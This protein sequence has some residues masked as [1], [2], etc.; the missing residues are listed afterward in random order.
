[1]RAAYL[2]L[3]LRLRVPHCADT[4][5]HAGG[6]GGRR[7]RLRMARGGACTAVVS[8]ALAVY[9]MWTGLK[10]S[11]TLSTRA[12]IA[13]VRRR[14]SRAD[15]TDVASLR[16]CIILAALHFCSVAFLRR[17]M[18]PCCGIACRLAA[19]LH[20]YGGVVFLRRCIL[21]ALHVASLR[22]TSVR[23]SGRA[24]DELVGDAR[25]RGAVQPWPAAQIGAECRGAHARPTLQYSQ[26]PLVHPRSTPSVPVLAVP[27]LR[28]A[29]RTS[30]GSAVLLFVCVQP[31]PEEVV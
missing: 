21:A 8:Q 23:C 7:L 5:R 11:P 12:G 13:P 14:S 9:W 27:L 30:V 25:R 28:S 2:P 4:R 19:A 16:R 31:P 6:C 26:Y 20:N 1:M 17:C 24:C 10:A 18:S 15:R 29:R 22:A 3:S